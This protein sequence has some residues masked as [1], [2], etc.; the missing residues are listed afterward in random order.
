[1]DHIV[2]INPE[3]IIINLQGP[4]LLDED[5]SEVGINAPAPFLAGIS[6]GRSGNRFTYA[7]VI[8]LAGECSQTVLNITKAFPACELSKTHNQKMLPTSKL[9]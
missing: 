1:M 4:C 5:L 8:Q 2:Q 6:K 9:F 7:G 3:I